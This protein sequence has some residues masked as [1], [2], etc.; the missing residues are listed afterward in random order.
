MIVLP[1]VAGLIANWL[2][3]HAQLRGVWMDKILSL[4]STLGI[5]IVLAIIVAESRDELLSVGPLLILAAGIHNTLGFVMGYY[6][7]TLARLDE[8]TRRTVAIEVGM[9]NCGMASGLAVAVLKSTQVAIPAAIF[10]P[11]MSISGAML[12]AWWRGQPAG[13]NTPA[14]VIPPSEPTAT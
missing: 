13:G 14:I 7:A 3:K 4:I 2:L 5:A 9:Q 11:W 1:I 10:G 6:G 12:A 8:S